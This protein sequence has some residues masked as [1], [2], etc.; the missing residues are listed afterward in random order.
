MCAYSPKQT[1]ANLSVICNRLVRDDFVPY[2]LRMLK[3]F[4]DQIENTEDKNQIR[5]VYYLNS[6]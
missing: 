6:F 4:P 5:K 1:N 3:Y 2:C